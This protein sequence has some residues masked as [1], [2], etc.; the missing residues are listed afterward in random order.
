VGLTLS[1]QRTEVHAH[2]LPSVL[3]YIKH[4][5]PQEARIRVYLRLSQARNVLSLSVTVT[6]ECVLRSTECGAGPAVCLLLNECQEGQEMDQ[7]TGYLGDAG[8]SGLADRMAHFRGEKSH[9]AKFTRGQTSQLVP[10]DAMHCLEYLRRESHTQSWG[11]CLERAVCAAGCG[12]GQAW[13]K[14]CINW[15]PQHLPLG[16]CVPF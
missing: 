2:P 1:R 4:L 12:E 5:S 16:C 10:Q 3:L 6:L 11:T 8:N 13:M 15:F 9:G 14:C 7:S